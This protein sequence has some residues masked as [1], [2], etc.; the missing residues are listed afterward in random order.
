MSFD[1]GDL[2]RRLRWLGLEVGQATSCAEGFHSAGRHQRK[3]GPIVDCRIDVC[4]DPGAGNLS[5]Q[6]SAGS[7]THGILE[8]GTI[9]LCESLKAR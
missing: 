3:V 2:E 7:L 1:S 8:T 6:G 9:V 5:R 4:G